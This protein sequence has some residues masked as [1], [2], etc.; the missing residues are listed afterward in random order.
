M[1]RIS[2]GVMVVEIDGHEYTLKATVSAIEAIERK[3][4][5]GMMQ[6]GQAIASV[7]VGAISF[8]LG[9][10][11]GLDKTG[12]EVLKERIISHGLADSSEIAADYLNMLL[13]PNGE[14]ASEDSSG[15]S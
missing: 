6:V 5:N 3:Y 11:A 8:I 1:S 15:E 4:P 12:I 9:K 7:S 10:A 2:K 14:E 13:N